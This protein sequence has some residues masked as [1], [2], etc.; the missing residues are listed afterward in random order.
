M[1]HAEPQDLDSARARGSSSLEASPELG[2]NMSRLLS[3]D[4][5]RSRAKD[6]E[7]ERPLSDAEQLIECAATLKGLLGML[8]DKDRKMSEIVSAKMG[9]FSLSCLSRVIPPLRARR[10]Q[11]NVFSS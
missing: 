11:R 4:S 5:R 6:G 8:I 3:F 1:K 2:P 9:E 7:S 10:I